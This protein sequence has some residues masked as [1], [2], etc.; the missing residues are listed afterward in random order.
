[1]FAWFSLDPLTEQLVVYPEKECLLL[2]AAFRAGNLEA[3]IMV[4]P[5]AMDHGLAATVL[6]NHPNAGEHLQRTMSGTGERLVRRTET[7]KVDFGGGKTFDVAESQLARFKRMAWVSVEPVEGILQPYSREN[8][9]LIEEKY[10]VHEKSA[11]VVVQLPSGHELDVS[12]SFDFPGGK[13]TQST[14]GGLRSVS[15]IC[16][17][18]VP[19]EGIEIPVY[20]RPE[21]GTVDSLRYRLEAKEADGTTLDQVGVLNVPED[22]FMEEANLGVSAFSSLK[23]MEVALLE[24]GH[25]I[26]RLRGIADLLKEEPMRLAA[27]VCMEEYSVNKDVTLLNVIDKILMVWKNQNLIQ[28]PFP[29]LY[30]TGCTA[31]GLNGEYK[32]VRLHNG[33]PFYQSA[34]AHKVLGTVYFQDGWKISRA[35]GTSTWSYAAATSEWSEVPPQEG[36][37]V[38]E[39]PERLGADGDTDISFELPPKVDYFEQESDLAR[40][41]EKESDGFEPTVA[42]LFTNFTDDDSSAF[43]SLFYHTRGSGKVLDLRRVA[44]S[45]LWRVIMQGAA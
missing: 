32:A 45:C 42:A 29:S 15:R 20:R 7:C 25:P 23:A 12:I 19:A 13:H 5:T 1:M 11:S 9:L 31:P 44:A 28:K 17:S 33:L 2:E 21:D 14:S 41:V 10:H 24:L 18:T 6:F 4:Q 37:T 16:C 39:S 34:C 26:E 36:W 8:A 40:A 30:I 22:V 27:N 43:A 35:V 3:T 38:S